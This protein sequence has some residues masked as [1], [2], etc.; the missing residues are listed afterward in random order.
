[1]IKKVQEN[2]IYG[3]TFKIFDKKDHLW[4]KQL[5]AAAKDKQC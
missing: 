1:M 4:T 3:Y 5:K 2:I